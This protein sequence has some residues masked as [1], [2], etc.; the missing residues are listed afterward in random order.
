MAIGDLN[1]ATWR[2]DVYELKPDSPYS[3]VITDL[4]N[5]YTSDLTITK[6]RNYPD[7]IRFTLDLQQL[8]ERAKN[9]GLASRDII[10]PYKHKIRCYRNNK[11]VAQAIVIKTTAN[12]NND[13]KNTIEVNCVDT[14]GIL[15]KRLIH[16]DYGEG[17]WADFAKEVIKDAQHEP[18]RIYNYAWEGDG[19]S[20][21]N[22]WFRGWKFTPGEDVL[23]DF[24]EWEPNHLYS[25]YD[26]CTHDAK[27]WE[28]KEHAFY[29]GETFSESNWTLLGILDQETGDVAGVYGVWREDN[30]EP[31]PTGTALGG[32]GGTSSCHMTSQSFQINNGGSISSISMK[33]SKVS[34]SLVA[35]FEADSGAPRLPLDYQEVEYIENNNRTSYLSTQY[36][37]TENTVAQIKFINYTATGESIFGCRPVDD[38]SDW[39]LFNYSRKIY[40][41]QPGGSTSP[42]K[43]II[44]DEGTCQIN[45]LYEF[46]LGNFY[47]KNVGASSPIVS[48]TTSTTSYTTSIPIYLNVIGP[49]ADI[50]SS[51]RWYYVKFFENGNLVADLVPCYRRSDNL[52][53]MYDVRRGIFLPQLGTGSFDVGPVVSYP[54][55]T[56]VKEL[57]ATAGTIEHSGSSPVITAVDD[58]KFGA[59]YA[60]GYQEFLDEGIYPTGITFSGTLSAGGTCELTLSSQPSTFPSL[61]LVIWQGDNLEEAA[62]SL[63]HWGITIAT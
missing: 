35:P 45:N 53:G 54:S 24:P 52:P 41:D 56:E 47:V 46:E 37:T 34:T 31:G 49:N 18:N 16:Q 32:W 57:T 22:A 55:E 5:L 13:S 44:G 40:F 1:P 61:Q 62:K 28:A 11:F 14:L 3:G 8:E 6:Q 9:L 2:I 26:T 38:L 33:D 42:G 23:R 58:E 59:M 50:A 12:L 15:E 4:S 39:R 17:S 29:S 51:N 19:T 25:M 30:E 10:Q 60:K 7:E 63:A 21:D 36:S 27:F 20:I 43:R 48:G